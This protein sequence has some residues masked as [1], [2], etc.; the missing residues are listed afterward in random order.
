M[1]NLIHIIIAFF[2]LLLFS[3]PVSAVQMQRAEVVLPIPLN[4]S[5]Y[6]TGTPHTHYPADTRAA[7]DFQIVDDSGFIEKGIPLYSPFD[8]YA[9]VVLTENDSRSVEI[10]SGSRKWKVAIAHVM[11]DSKAARKLIKTFP[12][13]V[14]KGELIAYQ[15]DSGYY[16]DERVPVHVHYEVFVVQSR[17]FE[18]TGSE[19]M[20]GRSLELTFEE[21]GTNDWDNDNLKIDLCRLLYLE[22][23]CDYVDEEGYVVDVKL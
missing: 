7:V 1:K 15:G 12:K 10:V 8:G 3:T 18:P 13:Y 21:L 16:G 11:D 14:M 17:G 5:F 2:T 9:R 4:S 22:K 23:Y 19:P 6:L 20:G